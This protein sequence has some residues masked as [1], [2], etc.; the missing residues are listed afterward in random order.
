MRGSATTQPQLNFVI[1]DGL[2]GDIFCVFVD[3]L[4]VKLLQLCCNL[5]G[6]FHELSETL[7]CN[8]EVLLNER[9]NSKSNNNNNRGSAHSLFKKYNKYVSKYKM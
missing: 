9:R 7:L 3:V 5:L 8:R 2:F 4:I 6:E 1:F